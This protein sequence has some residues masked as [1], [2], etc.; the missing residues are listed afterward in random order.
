M[1][2]HWDLYRLTMIPSSKELKN[3]VI[4]N[5]ERGDT[6]SAF[7]NTFDRN[8]KPT[9][10]TWDFFLKYFQ[11]HYDGT[12]IDNEA[13]ICALYVEYEWWRKGCSTVFINS[14]EIVNL[15][16]NARYDVDIDNLDVPNGVTSF[17]FPD[18]IEIEGILLRP[19]L[20]SIQNIND[21][22]AN[23]RFSLWDKDEDDFKSVSVVHRQGFAL[24]GISS[25]GTQKNLVKSLRGD[26]GDQDHHTSTFY[27]VM[28][29]VAVGLS[30]YM[31][32]F[33][34]A[35][36][37]GF[38]IDMKDRDIRISTTNSPFILTLDKSIQTSSGTHSSPVMHWRKG[39][40]KTLRHER[41]R[42]N[43][44]GSYKIIYVHDAIVNGRIDPKTLEKVA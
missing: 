22:L 5:P 24:P 15:V 21:S 33:P 26:F 44:D 29:K 43:P 2:R 7:L 37:D 14:P 13:R 30:I 3:L 4:S 9:E 18:G 27:K 38:P 34:N 8:K 17:S 23:K 39:H 32:A 36:R 31:K 6:I 12:P 1:S 16:Y 10:G 11:S 25:V 28:T 19:I 20:L 41:F 35:L 40:F 42:R